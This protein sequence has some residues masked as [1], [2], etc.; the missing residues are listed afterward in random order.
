M[1]KQDG[2]F[3]VTMSTAEKRFYDKMKTLEGQRMLAKISKQV[4][5]ERVVMLDM[6]NQ[7]SKLTPIVNGFQFK[8]DSNK[9]FV[10][11]FNGNPAIVETGETGLIKGVHYI[12]NETE[13][14]PHE[15]VQ[16]KELDPIAYEMKLDN[17][18]ETV[19]STRQF[20]ELKNMMVNKPV[21]YFDLATTNERTPEQIARMNEID[22]QLSVEGKREIKARIDKMEV[23]IHNAEVNLGYKNEPLQQVGE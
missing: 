10:K 3:T 1:S 21:E 8:S 6:K 19:K 14:K 11:M 15:Q 20:Y 17:N 22:Y 13:L 2:K 16:L 7:V 4:E 5:V 9:S 18:L 12:T 23:E